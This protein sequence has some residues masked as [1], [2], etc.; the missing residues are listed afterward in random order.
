MDSVS[1]RPAW[2]SSPDFVHREASGFAGIRVCHP[3]SFS[4]RTTTSRDP[5]PSFSKRQG[6]LRIF[7]KLE[8]QVC[9][10]G[11][12]GSCSLP[13]SSRPPVSLTLLILISC[14]EWVSLCKK[15]L[16]SLDHVLE[17]PSPLIFKTG[18][19]KNFLKIRNADP[20]QPWQTWQL[21]YPQLIGLF[22]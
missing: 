9:S 16:Q 10:P 3:C 2:L 11:G 7:L 14:W 15:I 13:S 17:R 21:L 20:Q 12:P 22:H 1:A 8:T 18:I 19:F 5:H 6:F 4:Q